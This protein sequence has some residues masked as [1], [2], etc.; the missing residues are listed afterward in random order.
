MIPDSPAYQT[1]NPAQD[2]CSLCG[3]RDEHLTFESRPTGRDGKL[4]TW[5][6]CTSCWTW[7]NETNGA[8]EDPHVH[9]AWLLF[10][11]VLVRGK[12]FLSESEGDLKIAAV[13][14]NRLTSCEHS[15]MISDHETPNSDYP[16]RTPHAAQ[17]ALLEQGNGHERSASEADRGARLAGREKSEEVKPLSATDAQ[18]AETACTP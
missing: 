4:Q 16:G 6:F 17:G 1:Q 10:V 5:P 14:K 9:H 3:H 12:R 7:F 15:N 8:G 18:T 13:C 2:R 11:T